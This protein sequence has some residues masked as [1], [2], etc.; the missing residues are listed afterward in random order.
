MGTGLLGQYRSH[1]AQ[2]PVANVMAMGIVDLL[3]VVDIHQHQPHR[4]AIGCRHDAVEQRA[5]VQQAGQ[6]V[7]FGQLAGKALL[8][9]GGIA[10]LDNAAHLDGHRQRRQQRLDAHR[11]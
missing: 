3:E 10:L 4:L 7:D 8:G 11:G 2:H 1:I 5:A 6:W 9:A